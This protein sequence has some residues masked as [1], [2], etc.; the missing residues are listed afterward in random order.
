MKA[1]LALLLGISVATPAAA[2][3]ASPPQ[4]QQ[5]FLLLFRPGPAWQAG[6][7]MA[8]QNLREHAA[9]HAR[10]VAESRSVAAGGYVGEEGGM[11]IIRAADLTEA[12]AML[13]ADPAI[14]NGVFVAE[15]RQ[16]QPR[17]FNDRPLV[18]APR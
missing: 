7:P 16:W 1:L 4:A 6:L 13:A 3:T 9:Y 14:Q 11:A 8:R 12:R 2:Q 10:L 15:L 18:E 17:Y 5:L